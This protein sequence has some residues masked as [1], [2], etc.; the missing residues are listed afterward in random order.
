MSTY[1]ITLEYEEH[2]KF[3]E[4]NPVV[5]DFTRQTVTHDFMFMNSKKFVLFFVM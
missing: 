4:W 1:V 3:D 2:N 5:T